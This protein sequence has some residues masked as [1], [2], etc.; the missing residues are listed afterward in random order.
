MSKPS[1]PCEEATQT[2]MDRYEQYLQAERRGRC[3]IRDDA[4]NAC[5]RSHGEELSAPTSHLVMPIKF[6]AAAWLKARSCEKQPSSAYA[7]IIG[8]C[9]GRR[10][11]R[12]VDGL[13]S[14]ELGTHGS[15]L[16]VQDG[17][18]STLQAVEV[19]AIE[20]AP[21]SSSSS[22]SIFA[23]K[24]GSMKSRCVETRPSTTIF[25]RSVACICPPG[26][27]ST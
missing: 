15:E 25:P 20:F 13:V 3:A 5:R 24:L 19:D 22:S 12:R 7:E 26:S 11:D 14:A 6:A 2:S 10:A 18:A 1:S 17:G 8:K 27:F 16:H 9:S 4:E 21:F 23:V